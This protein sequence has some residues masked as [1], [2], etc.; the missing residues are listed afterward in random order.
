MSIVFKINLSCI[1]ILTPVPFAKPLQYSSFTKSPHS[2]QLLN[3]LCSPINSAPSSFKIIGL[4]S[5]M[6]AFHLVLQ[7]SHACQVLLPSVSL[8]ELVIA[9]RAVSGSCQVHVRLWSRGAEPS[10]SS[11]DLVCTFLRQLLGE[12]RPCVEQPLAITAKLRIAHARATQLAILP[13]PGS[14]REKLAPNVERDRRP[15]SRSSSIVSRARLCES[16]ACARLVT[17]QMVVQERNSA[18]AFLVA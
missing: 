1:S 5:A 11:S 4:F 8:P 6:S 3:Y 18:A 17:L 12:Y 14:A 9:L 2:L 15:W 10:V 16:L 13:D 7:L